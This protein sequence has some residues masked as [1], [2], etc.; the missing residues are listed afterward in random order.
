[1]SRAIVRE[2]TVV[3][4]GD[5]IGLGKHRSLCSTP[6]HF[7][8]RFM[9]IAPTDLFD[10]EQASHASTYLPSSRVLTRLLAPSLMLR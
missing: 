1:M 6:T 10:F 3:R 2:G 8:A 5:P 9:G 7:E 4:A